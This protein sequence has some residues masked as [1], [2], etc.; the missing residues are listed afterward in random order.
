M[1]KAYI[2]PIISI[3]KVTDTDTITTSG[4]G[5]QRDDIGVIHSLLSKSMQESQTETNH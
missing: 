2:D 1:K 4:L 5:E 3:V